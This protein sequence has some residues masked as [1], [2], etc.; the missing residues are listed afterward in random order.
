MQICYSHHGSRLV[1]RR[2]TDRIQLLGLFGKTP[3]PRPYLEG[4]DILQIQFATRT[5]YLAGP[6]EVH[7]L[8]AERMQLVAL[9]EI[10]QSKGDLVVIILKDLTTGILAEVNYLL[11]YN[12]PT[13]RMWIRVRNDGPITLQLHLVR[14]AILHN[15]GA[16]G[17]MPWHKK[18][19][20]YLCQC[21]G[22][23][24]EQ[25]RRLPQ[26]KAIGSNSW[27]APDVLPVGILED[28]ETGKAWYWFLEHS[29]LWDWEIGEETAGSLSLW[30]NDH[31]PRQ[32]GWRMELQPGSTFKTSPVAFGLVLGGSKQAW[33]ALRAH[34][35]QVLKPSHCP[36]VMGY[37]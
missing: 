35:R 21:L 14:S 2:S 20:I 28:V 22:S 32:N 7:S 18:T 13:I 19:Y 25:W 3:L 12:S 23:G 17:I 4:G 9:Y 30:V 1:F 24:G 11:D 31:T 6:S 37:G 26:R 5:A 16:G 10:T 34:W 27:S 33:K 29:Y 15:L 36:S 8:S